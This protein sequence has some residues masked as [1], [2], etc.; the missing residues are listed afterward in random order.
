MHLLR[1]N[2]KTG[3]QD[4]LRE[5][6]RKYGMFSIYSSMFIGWVLLYKQRF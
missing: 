3:V 1:R 6:W 2:K 5:K 4:I